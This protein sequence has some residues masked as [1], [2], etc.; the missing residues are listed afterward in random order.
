MAYLGNSPLNRLYS[1]QAI[2][3]SQGQTAVNVTYTPGLC[4]VFKNGVLLDPGVDYTATDGSVITLANAASA[5]DVLRLL[6]LSQ[7]TF[8][9]VASETG[10]GMI[11]IA[12]TALAQAL[13]DDTTAITPKKMA[14]A[15]DV[16]ALGRNQTW[17]NVTASRSSGVTY[18]NTTGRPIQIA[19]TCASGTNVTT[20]ID[21]VVRGQSSGGSVST[22]S[23]VV[24]SGSTYSA[25]VSGAYL[26]H[27]LRS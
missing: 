2:A 25:S 14:D 1:S 10:V 6:N 16:T 26:W 23:Y 8:S 19:I 3:L 24:P 13:A 27:E 11:M 5:G 21:G 9:A 15:L 22:G 20:T 18:T 7:F 12:T 4:L 17:Q